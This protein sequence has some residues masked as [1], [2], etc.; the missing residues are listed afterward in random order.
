MM[1]IKVSHWELIVKTEPARSARKRGI[2][3]NYH[4]EV[5][6]VEPLPVISLHYPANR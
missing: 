2:F 3:K 5:V 1:N 4:P 6:N